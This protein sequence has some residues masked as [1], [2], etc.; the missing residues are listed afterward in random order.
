MNHNRRISAKNCAVGR[1]LLVIV[2]LSALTA[3]KKSQTSVP[4]GESSAPVENKPSVN[5]LFG[6]W[7]FQ[8]FSFFGD[9][10]PPAWEPNA[11][12][13]EARFSE[14]HTFKF[15]Q[16]GGEPVKSGFEL[17][18][19]P[20]AVESKTFDKF[21]D[22]HVESVQVFPI[23][24]TNPAVPFRYLLFG[25]G[26]EVT[27]YI[28]LENIKGISIPLKTRTNNYTKS[29][30]FAEQKFVLDRTFYPTQ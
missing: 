9:P 16:T 23:K 6:D 10:P 19:T 28:Y 26:E 17:G 7:K 4:E 11:L 13:G 18:A 1:A 30:D 5:T 8:D 25:P 20:I 24:F 14:D 21:G 27:M 12:S 2:F 3:C 29:D 15:V 22:A